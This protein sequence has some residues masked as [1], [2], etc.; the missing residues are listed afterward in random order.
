MEGHLPG[1]APTMNR[2]SSLVTTSIYPKVAVECL[3]A[4]ALRTLED[5]P[6]GDLTVRVTNTG[7]S[8]SGRAWRGRKHVLVKVGKPGHFPRK[9]CYPRFKDGMPEHEF[10]TWQEALV[11]VAAHEFMHLTGRDG[12]KDGEMMCEFAA[13]DAVDYYRKH[14]VEID[15]KIRGKL[16]RQKIREACRNMAKPEST[17]D[18][19]IDKAVLRVKRWERKL[20][21]AQTKLK[22]ARSEEQR[23]RRR[24]SKSS[25]CPNETQI[26]QP[27][28][29]D[30]SPV[31]VQ[32]HGHREEDLLHHTG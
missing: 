7:R 10:Q 15:E 28:P 31:S 2:I 32:E 12:T 30:V 14:Q 11:G 3:L 20:K 4:V 25:S 27:S 26:N 16:N 9:V 17:L 24:L 23:L 18:S 5:Y 8:Y 1:E 6:I 21:L 13:M 19:M 22:K 29:C